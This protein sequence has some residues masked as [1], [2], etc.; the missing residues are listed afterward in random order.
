MV[1]IKNTFGDTLYEHTI[2]DFQIGNIVRYK[3]ILGDLS[4]TYHFT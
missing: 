1:S 3:K 2:E 4:V